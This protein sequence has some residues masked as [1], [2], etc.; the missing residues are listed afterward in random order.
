MVFFGGQ[1]EVSGLAVHPHFVAKL[2]TIH[3]RSVPT[4]PAM[5][6]RSVVATKVW[7]QR[8]VDVELHVDPFCVFTFQVFSS[9]S[10]FFS[11][12]HVQM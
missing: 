4:G 6:V 8:P 7:A 9:T 5:T 12:Q 10:C 3:R 11:V 1:S 2:R